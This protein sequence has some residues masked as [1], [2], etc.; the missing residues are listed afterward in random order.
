MGKLLLFVVLGLMLA[1]PGEILN[2]ILARNDPSAFGT[3]LVSYSILLL[4]GWFVGKVVFRLIT[5]RARAAVIYY[6]LF[7]SLGLAVEWCLL[8]NAPVADPLQ[9]ITQPGMFSYW[10]TMLLGPRLIMD[11]IAPSGLRRSYVSFFLIYSL[12]YLLVAVTIPRNHGGIFFG[13]ILFAAGTTGL[14]YY[15]LRYFRQL[16]AGGDERPSRQGG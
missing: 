1:A 3:T 4:A 14:N 8:G 10:G 11:P 2:Q 6:L 7:G 9:V 16:T 15:Y 12:I 5:S 13:F